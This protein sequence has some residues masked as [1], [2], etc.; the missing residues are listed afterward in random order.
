M[1]CTK[2]IKKYYLKK[3]MINQKFKL[4]EESVLIN[5]AFRNY[6]VGSVKKENVCT[7]HAF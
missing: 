6:I 3:E 5:K 2:G 7:L 4:I 1:L